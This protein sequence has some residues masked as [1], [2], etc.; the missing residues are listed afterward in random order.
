MKTDTTLI[1]KPFFQPLITANQN[2]I[3]D[4]APAE[5]L[6]S[7]SFKNLTETQA[8]DSQGD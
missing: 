7:A 4:I 1:E 6:Q 8:A 3:E 5:I 2:R